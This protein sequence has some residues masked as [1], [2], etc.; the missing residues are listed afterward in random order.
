MVRGW[1]LLSALLIAGPA[2]AQSDPFAALHGADPAAGSGRVGST[3]VSTAV[4]R[5]Y[6]GS[7]ESGALSLAQI[8]FLPKTV[9]PLAVQ[10][11]ATNPKALAGRPRIAI[12]SY[13]LGFIRGSEARATAAGAG[14]EIAP[15]ATKLAT[16]LVGLSD[17]AAARLVDEARTDLV[18]RLTAAGF[19]VVDNAEVQAAPHLQGLARI[20][21]VGAGKGVIDSRATKYWTTYGPADAPLIRGE[22]FD[23]GLS[24]PAVTLATGRISQELDAVVLMPQLMIDHIRV[25][26]S[27]RRTY[28]GSAS[29]DAS[30]RFH[31]G[32]SSR[33]DFAYGNERGGT[34]GGAL[35]VTSG[36]TDEPFGV[37]Y[38]TADRSDSKALHN[39]LVEVGFGSI[40]RQSLAYAV[41]VA[42]ERFAALTRA[43]YQGFNA[44]LVDQI[45]AARR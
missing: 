41:E 3:G 8:G 36:G 19:Q 37:M 1:T 21:G 27:G 16:A 44:A 42:P 32:P 43:A 13:A 6:A 33:V 24:T 11:K 4:G 14:S 25:D 34:M 7:Q 20:S 35:T 5:S 10:V 40:Y 45:V 38:A 23:M 22:S 9:A 29:V 39:A 12:P 2:L 30:L 15:R 26:S 18:T 17:E 28:V 31:V